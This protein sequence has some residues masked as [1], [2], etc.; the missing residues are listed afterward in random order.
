VSVEAERNSDLIEV[1]RRG[2]EALCSDE[3]EA[4]YR[5]HMTED[6]VMAF[7]FGVMDKE[8]ALGA[9]AGRCP[10][11]TTRCRIRK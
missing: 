10:G 5:Q 2:W 6:V 1:E 7:P 4:Y 8:E 11:L 9:M 3:A